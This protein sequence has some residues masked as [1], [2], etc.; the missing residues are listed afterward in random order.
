[1]LDEARR[2]NRKLALAPRFGIRHRWAAQA[3]QGLLALAQLG[4]DRK[5]ALAGIAVRQAVAQADGLRVPVRVLRPSAGPARAVVLEIHGGGWVIGNARMDDG[6]NAALVHACGVAVVAV[7]YRL[8]PGVPMQAAMDDCLA[9]ARWL[10]DG[11]LPDLAGLPVVLL[12]ESAGGHLAAA[13]LLRLQ[14]WPALLARVAGAVLYYGV[15]DLTGTPSVRA[16]TRETLVLD[17]PG[18]VNGL[19]HLTPEVSDAARAAPP[20][21]PLHG[22][23]AGMPPAL[24]LAGALDPLRDDTLLMARRWAACAPVE[25]HL[26]PE[27]PH[28]F[29]RFPTQMARVAQARV[30]AWIDE[31]IAAVESEAAW[32]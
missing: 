3:V 19:R 10:L 18:I 12:G 11:G 31:R 25:C 2:F 13:T 5:L 4:A 26:L 21:S 16:A 8:L 15:Y 9:A 27:A 28:G 24:M 6:L 32:A 17:G 14:A 22:D 1:M 20:F 29:I 7:D 30:H 23:L